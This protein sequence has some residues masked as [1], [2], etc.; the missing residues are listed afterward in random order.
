MARAKFATVRTQMNRAAG[1]SSVPRSRILS[2]L[3]TAIDA[4][5]TAI[6]C[7]PS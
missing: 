6:H 1:S 3:K 5:E 2:K 7:G 4:A